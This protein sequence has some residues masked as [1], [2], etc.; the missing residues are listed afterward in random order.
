[1]VGENEL[2]LVCTNALISDVDVLVN[3]VV[4]EKSALMANVV[5]L[6]FVR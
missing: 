5:D 3:C 2:V 1:M 4:L 6:P